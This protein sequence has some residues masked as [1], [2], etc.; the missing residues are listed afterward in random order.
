MRLDANTTLHLV[1]LLPGEYGHRQDTNFNGLTDAIR[2]GSTLGKLAVFTDRNEADVFAK[3]AKK[4]A[5]ARQLL[6]QLDSTQLDYIAEVMV[7]AG[8]KPDPA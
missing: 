8:I 1:S 3:R 2:G 7:G 6:E 5:H 4:I